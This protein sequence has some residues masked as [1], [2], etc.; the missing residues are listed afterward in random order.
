MFLHQM[1]LKLKLTIGGFNRHTP[2]R[3]LQKARHWVGSQKRGSGRSGNPLRRARRKEL[4]VSTTTRSAE[5]K[6]FRWQSGRPSA[7]TL[8]HIKRNAA[9]T[10]QDVGGDA[11]TTVKDPDKTCP[12][13]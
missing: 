8:A 3:K 4:Y 7:G 1:Y 13:M 6:W 9:E 11:N 5:V 2:H 12:S 10:N